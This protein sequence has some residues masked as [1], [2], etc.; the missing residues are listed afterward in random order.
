MTPQT[1]AL[2][3]TVVPGR[4]MAVIEGDFVVFLVGMRINR[5]WKVHKWWPVAMAMPRMLAELAAHPEWG[6]L[7]VG[8]RAGLSVQYWRSFDHL[9]A[10]ARNPDAAHW[11]AWTAFNRRVRTSS[12]DVGIWHE[13]FLVRA[14]EYETLY[15]AMPRIGLALAG[16]HLPIAAHQERARQRLRSD[17]AI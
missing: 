8:G 9:E 14:G 15:G 7:A 5:W 10:Y 11:P 4:M 12:G 3:S 1:S 16:R 13:T 17:A 2:M 6:C